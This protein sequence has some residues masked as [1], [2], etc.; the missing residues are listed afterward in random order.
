MCRKTCL[1]L[2]L[3]MASLLWVACDSGPKRI[4]GTDLPTMPRVTLSS[5]DI[6][7]SRNG[8]AIKGTFV[9]TGPLYDALERLRWISRSYV[10]AG[11]TP[12]PPAGTPS[13]ASQVFSKPLTKSNLKRSVK[14][15][16]KASR[17]MGSVTVD[18][19]SEPSAAE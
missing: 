15:T 5:S 6:E 12:E 13:E 16:T 2:F 7:D 18:L 4:T 14:I 11:W 1:S 19:Y 3:L 9:F 10:S 17:T 8:V